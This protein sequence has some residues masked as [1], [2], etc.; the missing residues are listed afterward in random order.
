MALQHPL[1]LDTS[2]GDLVAQLGHLQFCAAPCRKGGPALRTTPERMYSKQDVRKSAVF[3][4][5]LTF[6]FS[7]SSF[8]GM[9]QSCLR[10]MNHAVAWMQMQ[11]QIC[12]IKGMRTLRDTRLAVGFLMLRMG[13]GPAQPTGRDCQSE[14]S[15]RE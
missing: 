10:T 5:F 15:S 6:D 7:M 11:I 4:E 12:P 3:S 14:I 2:L 13:N 9:Y 8:G 1:M